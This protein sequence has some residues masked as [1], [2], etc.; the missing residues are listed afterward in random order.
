MAPRHLLT[1]PVFWVCFVLDLLHN[2]GR[3]TSRLG[4]AGL[5][6]GK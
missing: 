3:T 6:Q 1:S 4:W 2:G 5:Y